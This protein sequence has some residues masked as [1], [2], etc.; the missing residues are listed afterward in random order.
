MLEQRIDVLSLQLD[1]KQSR[2]QIRWEWEAVDRL[3]K[4]HRQEGISLFVMKE[5]EDVVLEH[6]VLFTNPPRVWEP[7]AFQM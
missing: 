2:V 7:S 1:A 4:P 3:G 6:H 5:E